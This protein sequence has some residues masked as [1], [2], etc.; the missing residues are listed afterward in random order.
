MDIQLAAIII[1][2][3]ELERAFIARNM[4]AQVLTAGEWAIT[5]DAAETIWRKVGI[6]GVRHTESYVTWVR[7]YR[8]HGAICDANR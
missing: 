6:E 8:E 4:A 3:P 2:N 1:A 5:V 7:H